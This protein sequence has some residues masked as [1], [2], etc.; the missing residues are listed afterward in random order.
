M[1][2][3]RP[4]MVI[5]RCNA[6]KYGIIKMRILFLSKAVIIKMIRIYRELEERRK[7]GRKNLHKEKRL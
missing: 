5:I 2:K 4:I 7:N 1:T 3:N 6:E